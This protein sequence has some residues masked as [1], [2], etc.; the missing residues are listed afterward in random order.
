M[1]LLVGN[2]AP[3]FKDLALVGGDA[4]S[5]TPDNAFTQISLSDYKGKWLVFF[6]YPLDFTFVCPTELEEFGKKYADFKALNC[7]V[8][9]ASTD[10]HFSHY[11]WRVNEPKLQSLPYP[12]LADFT[13]K[14]ASDYQ[15]LKAETGYA[16]R[17]LFIIDPEGVVRYQIIHPESVGR[18]SSEVLRVLK[19]LQTGEKT[20]CNWEP[21]DKTLG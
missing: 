18:N 21:G 4:L 8:L 12:I 6:F 5:L 1:S 19:A 11:G 2:P 3:D 7:E 13:R 16:L 10:S 17:G 9:A 20:A 15:V 14:V